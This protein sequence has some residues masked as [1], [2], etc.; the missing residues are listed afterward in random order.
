VARQFG[1]DPSTAITEEVEVKSEER[2]G[3]TKAVKQKRRSKGHDSA[4]MEKPAAR[5]IVRASN[6]SPVLI[7]L[8]ASSSDEDGQR[9]LIRG[10][11]LAVTTPA[12]A[13]TAKGSTKRSK[14]EPSK[15]S[16]FH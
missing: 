16:S 11:G 15:R 4:G 9:G 12:V 6:P 14:S 1:P 2:V 8:T 5:P 13:K 3:S 7:D 10:R